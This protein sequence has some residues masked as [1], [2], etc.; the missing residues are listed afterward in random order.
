MILPS[1]DDLLANE[2]HAL[3]WQPSAISAINGQGVVEYL[4]EFAA[5]NSI[6]KLEPHADWNM[7]MRSG[8]LETQGFLEV[9]FGGATIYPGDMIT[10]T[11]ENGTVVGPE[12]WQAIYLSPGD[13]GPLQTGGDFYN[14][15]VLGLYPASYVPGED[16]EGRLGDKT[17]SSTPVRTP[18][19]TPS[20]STVVSTTAPPW[21]AA[22]PTPEPI[23]PGRDPHDTT[24]PRAFFLND[25]SVAVL[26]ITDFAAYEDNPQEFLRTVNT[27]LRRSKEAGLKKVVVDVQQNRG[28]LAFLA[29]ETFKLVSVQARVAPAPADQFLLVLSH[30]RAVCRKPQTCP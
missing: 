13:T 6:G 12:P 26:S 21:D 15:F 16:S 17:A 2:S 8:A 20:P 1:A 11:F 7:L 23:L 27:F 10:L 3:T 14:F 25:S 24:L 28:G 29:I 30:G 4:E 5:Q 22:Y 18:S 19:P 9:F